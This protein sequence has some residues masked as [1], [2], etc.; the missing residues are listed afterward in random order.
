MPPR[1]WLRRRGGET[2][3]MPVAVWIAVMDAPRIAPSATTAV[4]PGRDF[5]QRRDLGC[6]VLVAPAEPGLVDYTFVC[7]SS[8]SCATPPGRSRRS[9]SGDYAPLIRA[10]YSH[11]GLEPPV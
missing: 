4:R 8:T 5:A 1:F 10:L 7:R 3:G 2:T 11:E 9:T 6:E